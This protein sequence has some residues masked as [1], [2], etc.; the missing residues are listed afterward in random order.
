MLSLRY[1]RAGAGVLSR[2][3]AASFHSGTVNHA[4]EGSVLMADDGTPRMKKQVHHA[5]VPFPSFLK[6]P[7]TVAIIGA[8]MIYGQPRPGTDFGPAQLREAGMAKELKAL[9]WEVEDHGDI[10]IKPP[11]EDDPA[12]D[13]GRGTMRFG[14]CVGQACKQ[15]FDKVYTAAS[16]G[17][18]ALTLGGDHSIGAGTVAGILKARPNTGVIWVDAHAD[19]NTPGVSDSGNI[20]G[21]PVAFLA[22][23][24]DPTL[25][26]GW[27]WM[28]DTPKLHPSQI[29]Y[30]GLRDVDEAERMI[31][32][33][34]GIT[35]FTMQHV[36]RYGI[37]GVMERTL[38]QLHGRPLH[39]SYDVDAVDPL[40]APSTGTA[41]RGG[42]TF[43]EAN[44]VV[45]ALSETGHLGSLDMVEVN[46]SLGSKTDNAVTVNM[47][48]ALIDSALGS[49][50]I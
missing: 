33:E 1:A 46:P 11:H 16:E 24:I 6:T 8:P 17:K 7:K 43:R 25:V 32:K 15:V 21:M 38:D 42:L 26:P 12:M 48:L 10:D 39:C 18:F 44:Y 3:A 20:H 34:L 2:G 13:Q 9:N 35:C 14:Y 27:E 19:I 22:R 31:L 41:V 49:R 4:S 47:A 37:G 29:V 40:H 5:S 23:L 50:I 30:I 28:V 45:E 36:D